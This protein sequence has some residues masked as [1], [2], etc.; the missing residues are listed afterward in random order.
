MSK[1]QTKTLVI[2]KGDPAD[3]ANNRAVVSLTAEKIVVVSN[4]ADLRDANDKLIAT[5]TWTGDI[6]VREI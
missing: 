2:Y 6:K 5:L 1:P 4:Y 3:A